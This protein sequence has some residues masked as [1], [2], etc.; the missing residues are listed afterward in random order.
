MDTLLGTGFKSRIARK[1]ESALLSDEVLI[2][3]GEP[4]FERV[5]PRPFICLRELISPNR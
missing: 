3:S 5:V 1:T 4:L 2:V